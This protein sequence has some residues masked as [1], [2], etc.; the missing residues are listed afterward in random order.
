MKKILALCLVA[1]MTFP[2][3]AQ[4]KE[5]TPEFDGYLFAYFEGKGRYSEQEQLRFAVSA[6][7]VNWKALNNNRPIIS[8]EEISQTG[9][10]RDPYLVR[11]E[12]DRFYMVA[13]DMFTRKDG[14]ETNP[15]II[16]MKSDNLIDWSHSIIDL[17]KLYPK[18]FGKVKWVWAPQVIYDRKAGKYLVYFTVRLYGEKEGKL[19]F[20]SAYANKDFTGFEDEPKLMFSPKYGGIDGDII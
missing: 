4:T 20:Y 8:S 7:A 10:I 11:G 5:T 13:T 6:D 16:L 14:W 18:K 2:V 3:V 19:D 15:G 1:I 17:A 12:E 9:G